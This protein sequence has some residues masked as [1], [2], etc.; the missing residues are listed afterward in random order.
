MVRSQEILS[1]TIKIRN[2]VKYIV[3]KDKDYM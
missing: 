1:K 2:T 3:F